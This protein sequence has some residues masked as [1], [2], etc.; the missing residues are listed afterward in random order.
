MLVEGLPLLLGNLQ[1][2]PQ[3][4]DLL[5]V[6]LTRGLVLCLVF[7]QLKDR[8]GTRFKHLTVETPSTI[9]AKTGD[10]VVPLTWQM[11]SFS[12]VMF[13]LERQNAS[14]SSQTTSF[15]K[16]VSGTLS[17][18]SMCRTICLLRPVN[19][20]CLFN[21]E[22]RSKQGRQNPDKPAINSFIVS[23]LTLSID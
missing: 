12:D 16:L 7:L 4:L 21:C 17:S 20:A 18:S 15:S 1:S 22:W 6:T 23:S 5:A 11:S 9:L 14:S 10:V 8:R 2:T 19:S 3:L 13:S